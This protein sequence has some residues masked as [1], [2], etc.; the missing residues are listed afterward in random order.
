[1][2]NAKKAS[3]YMVL[4]GLSF[5]LS[6][7]FAE[8]AIDSGNFFLTLTAR[9]MIPLVLLA[10]FII[11][12][13][14]KSIFWIN[15]YKQLPR[16][17][18][19]TISQALFFLCAI[20]T[21]LFIAMVLYNTGPIFICLFTLFS[22]KKR[23]T[24][25]E[26]LSALTGF[27]GVFLILKTGSVSY[28]SFFYLGIGVLS[29]VSL[30]LSQ[31]FLH[32]SAQTDDNLSI[33]AYTYLY[34]T[35]IAGLLSICFAEESY[36]KVLS[37]NKVMYI[38]LTLMA[39][40]SLG[41]QWFRGIAYKLTSRISRVSTLLYFNILFSLLLDLFFNNSIPSFIQFVG[42]IC[43]LVSGVIPILIQSDTKKLGL[44]KV[45]GS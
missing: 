19:I 9:F 43:V 18:S 26:V 41:N 20:K 2:D 13:T 3:F 28:E 22:P 33:M 36:L 42:A 7:F 37:G 23:A 15:S 10:P 12:R 38:F 32:K 34:G 16:A 14:R 30:A 24:R 11:K 39:V 5:S 35:I 29:G 17:F 40:G 1:M 27:L 8:H 4:S 6:G 45:V 21:S 44:K 25:L 31:L